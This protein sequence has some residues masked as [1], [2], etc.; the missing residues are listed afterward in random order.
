MN[1]DFYHQ[2]VVGR[3][4]HAAS[5]TWSER[6]RD[7]Y[8]RGQRA[9][10]DAILSLDRR[11]EASPYFLP[12]LLALLVAVLFALRGRT[13][14]RYLV[15]RWRLRAHRG[16]NLT[17]GLA[18]LEYS[19]LLRLLEKRGWKKSPSQTALEFASGIAV[20]ELATPV[21]EFTELYQRARFGSGNPDALDAGEPG[22]PA[23]IEQMSALLR[24]IR[25]RLS[26]RKRPPR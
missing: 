12:S 3:S 1:Y 11:T 8:Q 26:S 24:A 7:F 6:A 5:R 20:P 4:I 9:A 13:I 10:L 18:T 2:I 22:H 14:L 16:G 17:A 25:N 23:R 19:E 21:M 15:A